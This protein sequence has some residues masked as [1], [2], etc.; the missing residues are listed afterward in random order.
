M[1]KTFLDLGGRGRADCWVERTFFLF[2][3][4]WPFAV[5]RDL[6]S[7]FDMRSVVRPGQV[8]KNPAWTALMKVAGTGENKARW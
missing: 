7:C 4:M 1:K 6:G 2:N 5:F 3:F 8:A